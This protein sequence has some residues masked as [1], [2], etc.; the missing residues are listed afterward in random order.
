M[1]RGYGAEG[2][3]IAYSLG[4]KS[5][6]KTI[7]LGSGDTTSYTITGLNLGTEYKIKMRTEGD[8][9]ESR[10]SSYGTIVKS[11]TLSNAILDEAFA[12]LFEDDFEL[13]F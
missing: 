9:E 11:T 10:T 8:G 1:N 3:T 4:N 7:K 6:F 5:S 2:Y 13:E 12:E